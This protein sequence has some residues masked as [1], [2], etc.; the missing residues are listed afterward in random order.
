MCDPLPMYVEFEVVQADA[1]HD[2]LG[3]NVLRLFAGRFEM[4]VRPAFR[5]GATRGCTIRDD[6]AGVTFKWKP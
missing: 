6:V 5:L 2:L 4:L 3:H 1:D